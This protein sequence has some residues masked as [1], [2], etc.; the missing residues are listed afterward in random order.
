MTPPPFKPKIVVI[1]GA[2]GIGKT[3]V[4][5]ELA[6]LLGGEIIS[7]DSMQ[8]YR[9]MDIGTA[10]PTPSEVA[11]IRHHMID[12]VNPDEDYDAVRFSRQ[13]RE[14]IRNIISRGLI[15]FVVGGTGLYIKA[16]LHGLFESRPVDPEIRSRLRRIAGEQGGAYLFERLKQVDP[17]TAG[18]LHPNDAY[19]IIRALETIE[20][21]GQSISA[22]HRNHRFE[23]DPF[24]TFKIGLQ[25]ERPALYDRIDRRVELMVESGLVKEVRGLLNAGYHPGLKS[26]QSIGYRHVVGYLEE[27]MPWDE[28]VRTLQRDTR[29]FA[30]RQFTWFGADKQVH[31]FKPDRLDAMAESAVEFLRLSETSF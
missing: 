16:L 3:A 12:I 6:E 28:C 14:R 13:A 21:S 31:W 9:Y 8:I 24:W 18:R 19:R 1:C 17:E 30:K 26:M 29:R 15:P 4:G 2:T 20:S 25:M 27:K 5:I 7:A 11:R 10:K 22:L 23:D